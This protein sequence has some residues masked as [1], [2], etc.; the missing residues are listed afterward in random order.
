ML[1]GALEF[2]LPRLSDRELPLV[3]E[4]SQANFSLETCGE[5][6]HIG[7]VISFMGEEDVV[8]GS[9][10]IQVRGTLAVLYSTGA[11]TSAVRLCLHFTGN[12]VTNFRLP[13]RTSFRNKNRK[14]EGLPIRI[15]TVIAIYKNLRTP[16]QEGIA[17]LRKRLVSQHTRPPSLP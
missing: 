8:F 3:Q 12:H 15:R 7:L 9:H 2:R 4:R 14:R 17:V 1:D 16:A 5:Q 10:L 11:V 6:F 13:D